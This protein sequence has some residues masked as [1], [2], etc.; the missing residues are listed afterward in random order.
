MKWIK[1]NESEGK[2]MKSNRSSRTRITS[3]SLY[4]PTNVWLVLK[5]SCRIDDWRKHGP[6]TGPVRWE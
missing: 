1:D 2:Q 4:A 6:I 5:A 3:G